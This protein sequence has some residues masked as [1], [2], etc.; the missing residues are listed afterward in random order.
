MPNHFAFW[1]NNVLTIEAIDQPAVRT[2]SDD[3]YIPTIPNRPL[4]NS[5]LRMVDEK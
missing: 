3:A 1:L 5:D 2:W 4:L